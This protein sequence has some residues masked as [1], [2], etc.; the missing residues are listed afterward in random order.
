MYLR[1]TANELTGEHTCVMRRTLDVSSV[2]DPAW[3]GAYAKD[4]HRRFLSLLSYQFRPFSSVQALSIEESAQLGIKLDPSHASKREPLAKPELDALLSPFD[5]K[6]LDSYANNMLDYHVILDLLP[7]IAELFFT[8]R[9]VASDA[10]QLSGVQKALLCAIGLQRKPLDDVEKELHLAPSQLLSM[11]IKVARKISAHFRAV[12]EGDAA[13]EMPSA[14]ENGAEG[15]N[16][17]APLAQSLEADLAQG[18]D[19]VMT[20]EKRRMR[21]MIDALPLDRYVTTSHVCH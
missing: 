10:L 1:Q 4:F 18:A 8:N 11:F 14:I 9:L 12:L 2:S 16:D 21:E 13:A 19:E 15:G 3:L 20:E 7:R 17:Y 5:L 6:R